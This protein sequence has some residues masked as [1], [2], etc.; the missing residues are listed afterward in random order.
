M[1]LSSPVQ[2]LSS[3]VGRVVDIVLRSDLHAMCLVNH[4]T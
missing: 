2:I 3:D 1:R 4:Y